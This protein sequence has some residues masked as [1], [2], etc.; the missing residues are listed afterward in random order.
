MVAFIVSLSGLGAVLRGAS[1][2]DARDP[3]RQ[4]DLQRFYGEINRESFGGKLPEVPVRWG[5]LTKDDAYG[6]TRFERGVPYAME[7][8]RRTVRSA[9]FAR[10]VIRHESCHIA[11]SGEAK[12]RKEDAHGPTFV[13][14]MARIQDGENND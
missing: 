11:T 14:C 7:L 13:A 12:K 5:D 3:V 8:D 2:A 10:D 9:S 1:Y 4:A 6:I